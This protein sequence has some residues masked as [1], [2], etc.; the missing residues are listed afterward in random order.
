MS[1]WTDECFDSSDDRI[2][3]ASDV[4]VGAGVG[5]EAIDKLVRELDGKFDDAGVDARNLFAVG[6][7]VE[8][9][10]IGVVL[11]VL[12][13][14]R[15]VVEIMAV[16]KGFTTVDVGV[17]DVMGITF[18]VDEGLLDKLTPEEDIV[19]EAIVDVMTDEV[20]GCSNVKLVVAVAVADVV[21]F[22]DT[23]IIDVSLTLLACRL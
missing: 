2:V 14:S 1:T 19:E 5:V 13:L 3:V 8:G 16:L 23:P 6:F 7:T 22:L 20:I 9:K 15:L 4:A 18:I 10:N 17:V 11:D 21:S 12:G